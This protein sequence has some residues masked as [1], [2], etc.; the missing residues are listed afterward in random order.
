MWDWAAPGLRRARA[1]LAISFGVARG[2]RCVAGVPLGVAVLVALALGLVGG[3]PQAGATFPGR[4]GN[5]VF[6]NRKG[7]SLIRPDGLRPHTIYA[8]GGFSPVFAPSGRQIAFVVNVVK[9][10]VDVGENL[11]VANADGSGV[12][13]LNPSGQPVANLP[14]LAFSPNGRVL[15][16]ADQPSSGT[17]THV[18]FVSVKTGTVVHSV[19]LRGQLFGP[20]WSTSGYLL[21]ESQAGIIEVARAS[22]SHLRTLKIRFRNRHLSVFPPHTLVGSTWIPPP[23]VLSLRSQSSPMSLGCSGPIFTLS[24]LPAV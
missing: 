1:G 15:A 23:P 8:H 18:V 6:V 12:R 16:Y 21:F 2:L 19:T 10:N 22:G 11:M 14:G 17:T 4:N 9:G 13:Q 7:I 3:A 24:A 20:V 5:L